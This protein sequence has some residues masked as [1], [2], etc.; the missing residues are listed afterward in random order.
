MGL[1]Q[2]IQAIKPLRNNHISFLF[3][4]KS[5]K[6]TFHSDFIAALC[7]TYIQRSEM[8]NEV[9][10][11]HPE[12]III[13]IQFRIYNFFDVLSPKLAFSTPSSIP[14]KAS[15]QVSNI[16]KSVVLNFSYL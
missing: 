8:L 6:F 11:A 1:F 14:F 12:G 15:P 2:D 7:F 9:F 5:D 4:L 13:F 10:I 3:F 16:D